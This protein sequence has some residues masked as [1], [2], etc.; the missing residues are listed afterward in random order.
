[1]GRKPKAQKGKEQPKVEQEQQAEEM[2][3]E[4]EM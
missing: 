2:P 3:K 1:M 4:E